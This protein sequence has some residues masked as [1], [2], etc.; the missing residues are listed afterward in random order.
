MSATTANLEKMGNLPVT[1]HLIL[2]GSDDTLGQ[3][4]KQWMI[5]MEGR[6]ICEGE[7]AHWNSFKD[8]LLA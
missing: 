4:I 1:P 8:A 5:S 7:H 2:P 3:W 6:V